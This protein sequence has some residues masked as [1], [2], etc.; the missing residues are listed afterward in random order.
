VPTRL[1]RSKTFNGHRFVTALNG[2]RFRI[3][4]TDQTRKLTYGDKLV[5][6]SRPITNI[7]TEAP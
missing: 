3:R 6:A 1:F 7:V 4:G 2:S 5:W